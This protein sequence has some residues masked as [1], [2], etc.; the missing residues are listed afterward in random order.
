M[1]IITNELPNN[2]RALQDEVAKILAECGLKAE[3]A[4]HIETVRGPVNI[5]VYAE[6]TTQTPTSIYLCEC[7]R[8]KS[9]VP[10]TIVH[11]FRTVVLDYGANWGFIISSKNFQKGAYEAAAN[12]N[13][14]LL[15]WTSFQELFVDRWIQRHMLPQLFQEYDALVEY[16][17]PI[18]SR[19]FRKA[20]RFSP[21]QKKRFVELRKKYAV[22]AFFAVCLSIQIHHPSLQTPIP[23]LPMKDGITIDYRNLDG[24]LPTELIEA[25]SLR[26]FLTIFTNHLRAGTAEFDGLFGGRA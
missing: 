8:W 26:Q 17:E 3:V 12:S 19:I 21:P 16:T 18:N 22:L 15:S 4:K 6:D 2:W 1:N 7:K 10:K 20:E 11:A 14:K 24:G 9:S 13:I 23:S 25:S 5:D